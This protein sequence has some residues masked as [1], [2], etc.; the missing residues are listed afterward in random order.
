LKL[1]ETGARPE[2]I[3]AMESQVRQAESGLEVARSM[4]LSKS[5]EQDIDMAQARYDQAK[6]GLDASKAIEKAKSWEAEIAASEAAVKQAET[7][8]ELAK[9]ALGYATITAPIS[10]T[11]SKRNLDTGS[12]ANPAMP[13]FTIVN[14][15]NVKAIVDVPEASL[16]RI[17]KEGRVTISAV[18]LSAPMSGRITLISPVIKPVSRTAS[19]EISIDNSSRRLRPGSFARVN[20]TLNAKENVTLIRRSAIVEG[21]NGNEGS[22][23]FVLE[24][25]RSVKRKIETGIVKSDVVEV[26]SGLQVGEKVI[27]SGQNQLKDGD[28]V[29]A[30]NNLSQTSK[31]NEEICGQV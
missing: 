8:L 28:R 17:P 5:W 30:S 22:Y 16:H 23:V 27:I 6:A 1:V 19:L 14:V 3:L 25:D 20:I 11:V 13:L 7:A 9:E 29:K 24:N 26:L 4:S 12:M 10:G 2:D 31:I 15:N 21:N 18:G